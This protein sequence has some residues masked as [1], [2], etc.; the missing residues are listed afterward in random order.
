MD[1]ED[2]D[3]DVEVDSTVGYESIVLTV[4]RSPSCRSIFK[5]LT[6]T[7]ANSVFLPWCI[8]HSTTAL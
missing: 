5:R 6:A 4:T 1:L 3:C 8:G 7:I 2:R